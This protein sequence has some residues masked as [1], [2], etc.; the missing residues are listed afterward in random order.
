MT[1][2]AGGPSAALQR[3]AGWRAAL[4]LLA[5][6]VAPAALILV[7]CSGKAPDRG[8]NRGGGGIVSTNPCA[9]A[10]LIDLLPPER[11]GAIS[12][13][14]RDP[15]A[16]SV[17]VD[18]ARRFAATAGTAEEVI[19][20][21]PDLVVTS[22]MT[23]LATRRAYARAGLATLLLDSPT[24]IAASEA[25]IRQIGGA[26]GASRAAD[27]LVERIEAAV[28]RAATAQP[29]TSRPPSVLL[30]LSGDLA[31]GSG[32]LLDAE[33]AA[34]GFVNAA[35]GYGLTG[36]ARLPIE[37]I[38]AAPPDLILAT[39]ASRSARLRGQV[40]SATGARTRAIGWP[41]NLVFC[42]GPTIIAALARLTALRRSAASRAVAS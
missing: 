34:A 19:V 8:F 41:R 1:R 7:G 26:V 18:A 2:A 11:I 32:N 36:T 22:T 17:G 16:T 24:T 15:G 4:R 23:P 38:A 6:W 31:S 12:L 13:L 33:L 40:L 9:D 28:R 30:F 21:H 35:A 10:I 3:D 5:G 29:R 25:Q 14:S 39:D 37:R 27:R 20:R 42:G